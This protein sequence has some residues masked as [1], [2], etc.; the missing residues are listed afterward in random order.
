MLGLFGL[1]DTRL[2]AIG[3]T[4]GL[5]FDLESGSVSLRRIVAHSDVLFSPVVGNLFR[6]ADRFETDFFLLTGL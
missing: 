4:T 2:G 6:T 3:L 1:T 5:G